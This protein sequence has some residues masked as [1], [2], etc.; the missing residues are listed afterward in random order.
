MAHWFSDRNSK[1][2]KVERRFVLQQ[3]YWNAVF[4]GLGNGFVSS[5]LVVYLAGTYG[6]KGFATSLILAAPRL[7]G[8]LR[9][10]TPILLNQ[11]GDYRQFCGRVFLASSAMLLLL[12]I[13]SAPG[14]F[15]NSTTSLAALVLCWTGYHLLEFLGTI[16]LWAWIGEL[17]PR[18]VRGRFV[19]RR[20]A[21][22][23]SFQVVGMLAGA[24]GTSW[25][26]NTRHAAAESLHNWWAYVACVA[27]GAVCFA[28][29]TI[30]FWR[31]PQ[32][33]SANRVNS[34]TSI[35]SWSSILAPF[36]DPQFRR[37]LTYGGWFS[38]ANGITGSAQFLF[39][40][41]VL[42]FSYAQRL[43]L[44]GTSQAAQSAVMP[45]IGNQI[46][47][48]GNVPVLVI[49]QALVALG[50]VF[51]LL[52]TPTARWWVAAA[53]GMW[54]AY[55]GINVAMPNLVLTLARPQ[56]YA[57]YAAAWFAWTQLVYALTTLASGLLFDWATQYWQPL[58]VGTWKL[59]HFA[60]IFFL[61][62]LLRLL[63]VLLAA[64]VKE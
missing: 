64:R 40:M 33:W 59:D 39:Q 5:S 31:I 37:Y 41:R 3:F 22:L 8:V 30:P 36:L 4:W 48:R 19:G 45:W 6:T 26:Q 63:A 43:G 61:G 55:A 12:P 10:G 20:A 27:V 7:V 50:M 60:A 47:R 29:A 38:L 34:T 56:L 49:S 58:S 2:N 62:L 9:L 35:S 24:I 51:F 46:D 17:V 54:V 15:S 13:V 1:V 42:D 32:D 53:Y 28:L 57:S 16:A 23:N 11:V 52:A 14:L 25:W 18:A 21:L 44:D